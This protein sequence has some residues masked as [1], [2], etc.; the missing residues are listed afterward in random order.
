MKLQTRVSY[1]RTPTPSLT[2]ENFSGPGLPFSY[3]FPNAM[4]TLRLLRILPPRRHSD[5]PGVSENIQQ[6]SR[7]GGRGF[8][9]EFLEIEKL[10]EW[11]I[12][13]MAPCAQSQESQV[14]TGIGKGGDFRENPQSVQKRG[15]HRDNSQR[16]DYRRNL[17]IRWWSSRRFLP[18]LWWM[19]RQSISFPGFTFVDRTSERLAPGMPSSGKSFG[20]VRC[21]GAPSPEI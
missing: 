4:S 15:G 19:P 13:S 7:V 14:N 10:K 12:I 5:V 9:G 3:A 21:E 18:S 8:L 17:P 2:P 11:P 1:F 6:R 20:T 16:G